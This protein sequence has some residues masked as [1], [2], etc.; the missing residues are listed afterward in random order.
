MSYGEIALLAQVERPVVTTW[1]RRHP[2]FPAPVPGAG[3]QQLFSAEGV[4]AWLL[5]HDLGNTDP[6]TLR[7]ERALHTLTAYA[8]EHGGR[9]LV[10]SLS[11][12][13]CL[14]HLLG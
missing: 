4:L 12:A 14:R 1:R 5:D 2:D 7:A 8:R 10:S 9:Q 13:V 6:G 3:G 11:A